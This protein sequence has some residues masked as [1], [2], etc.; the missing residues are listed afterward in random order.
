M[1]TTVR[2]EAHCADDVEVHIH[3]GGD[4]PVIIQNGEVYESH[5]YDQIAMHICELPKPRSEQ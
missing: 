3:R 2:V 1:T 4:Q 5:V